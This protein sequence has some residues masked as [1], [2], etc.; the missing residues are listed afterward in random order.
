ML[1]NP[2]RE[3]SMNMTT[4]AIQETDLLTPT[5]REAIHQARQEA[6]RMEAPEVYP[7]HIFLGIIAQGDIG[8]AK[9][10]SNLGIDMQTIR[11]RIAEIFSARSEIGSGD[12][13]DSD[14]P[15]ARDAQNCMDWAY[16]QAIHLYSSLIRP[17]HLLLGV[18][19]H[20]RIQPLLALLLS[21]LGTLPVHVIEGSESAYTSSIDQLIY[22]R[23]R[24]QSVVNLSK[25]IRRRVLRRFERPI[26]TFADILGLDTAKHELR[27]VVEFLR[28]PNV[29][30]PLEGKYMYGVLLVGHPCSDR[31]A[32]VQATA[33][34]AVVPLVSLSISTL[35][36]MLAELSSGAVSV[37]DLDLS[38]PEYNLLESSEGIQRGRSMIRYVFQEAKDV[39][40][41]ILLLDDLDAINRLAT[42]EEREQWQK[43][44]LVEIDG[45]DN[46][47]PM[48]VFATTSR[49]D[50][51]ERSLLHPSRFD[52]RVVVSSSFMVE[53]AAQ[54]KLCLSCKHEGLSSWKYC[55]YCGAAL[56]KVC[57]KCGSLYAEIEGSLFCFE[58]GNAWSSNSPA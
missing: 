29:F 43:Q 13:V 4:T 21:P 56:S 11:A 55:V 3:G 16:S 1:D 39:S 24:E 20:P 34:E 49:P 30:Q 14:L 17:E 5:T 15:L 18:L 31:M 52:R 9:V 45:L 50:G 10:L 40:P 2:L 53:P 51:I 23:V 57:P 25:G 8:V 19:R 32:L 47:P 12:S 48:A 27:E 35:V 28:K 26:I 42:K 6:A 58:C 38:R 41:C 33:G 36:E 22:S 7:E 46:H 54:T 37:E 44:L